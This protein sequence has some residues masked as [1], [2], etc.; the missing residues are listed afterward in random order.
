MVGVG[1]MTTSGYTVSSVGSNQLMLWL[2]VI[3]GVAALCGALTLAELA[4]ALP[5]AGGEYAILY[6]AYGPLAGFLWGWVTLIMGFAAPIAAAALTSAS[7]LLTPLALPTSSAWLAEQGLATLTVLIFAAIH[8]SGQSRTVAVQGGITLLKL[9]LIVAFTIAGLAVGWRHGA[10]LADRPPITWPVVGSMMS[11]LVFISYAYFGWNAAAY[12]AGEIKDPARRLPQALLLGTG[13]VMLLYLAVN[14]VYALALPAA[15]IRAID[16][17]HPNTNAVAP[18][19]ELAAKRLFGPGVANFVSLATGL[20]LLSSLSAYV[21][22]A[23]RVAYAMAVSGQ[24]P[25]FA[26]R[27]SKRFRTPVVATGC[28]VL[29]SLAMLWTGTFKKIVTYASVGMA[30]FSLLTI[31]A[32]YVLR[33]RSPDLPR[34]FRTPGYPVVPAIYLLIAGLL[35]GSAFYEKSQRQAATY[36]VASI[37]VG[38]PVFYVWNYFKRPAPQGA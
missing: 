15:D 31:G 34:P 24:F 7:Y 3:G 26:G 22:A 23:P 28:V 37:L 10:N 36:A 18:I 21:L 13:G 32:I 2:W 6:E 4:A 38:V 1:I 33:W 11:S 5:R 27:V 20:M 9:G 17:A 16:Q 30:L 25:A 8:S 19:A 14:V 12:L 29:I 35:I